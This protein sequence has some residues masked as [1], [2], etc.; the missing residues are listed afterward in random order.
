MA[1]EGIS[2]RL[3]VAIG[4]LAIVPAIVYAVGRPSLSGYVSAV[5]VVIIFA[6]LYTA[7]GPLSDHTDTT[8]A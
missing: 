8:G 3:V 2:P 1:D 7:F 5:N 6:A 4:L